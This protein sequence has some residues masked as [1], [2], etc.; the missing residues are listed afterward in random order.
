MILSAGPPVACDDSRCMNAS[1]SD[2]PEPPTEVPQTAE[3]PAAGKAPDT[4]RTPPL[5]GESP[6]ER[7]RRWRAERKQRKEALR[8][9]KR[10][11]KERAQQD[12]RK[13]ADDRK[14][15][16]AEAKAKKKKAGSPGAPEADQEQ[17]PREVAERDAM[18]QL[19]SAERREA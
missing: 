16:K 12:K 8:A 9:Q 18:A 1:S 2:R 15:L 7:R 3:P 5:T 14:R 17:L 13:R 6:K 4:L 19:E 10:A 11:A